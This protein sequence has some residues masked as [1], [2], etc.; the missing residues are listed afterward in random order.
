MDNN[1]FQPI[2]VYFPP[3][4]WDNLIFL[5]MLMDNVRICLIA[6][7]K[8]IFNSCAA[9]KN[10]SYTYIGLLTRQGEIY[11][12]YIAM[13][14]VECFPKESMEYQEIACGCQDKRRQ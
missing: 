14:P 4:R 10:K 2:N 8:K 5:N 7:I 13:F 3:K 1:H 12:Q 9:I 11:N 6:I